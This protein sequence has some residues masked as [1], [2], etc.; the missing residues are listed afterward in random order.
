MEIWSAC[1]AKDPTSLNKEPYKPFDQFQRDETKMARCFCFSPCGKYF[2]WTNGRSVNICTTNNWK[3]IHE[4][5][6][7]RAFYLKFSPKGTYLMTWEQFVINKET[8]EG[9]PNL[10]IYKAE[11]GEDVFN[12]IQKRQTD[13]EPNWS[14]DEVLV[15]LMIGGEVLFYEPNS[16]DGFTK[17]VRKLGGKNGSVSMSPVNYPPHIAFYVPGVKAGM[18]NILHNFLIQIFINFLSSIHVPFIQVSK[19]G[20]QSTSRHKKVIIFIMII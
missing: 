4:L 16:A 19:F 3:I 13:W 7:P 20:D 12:I 9:A 8:Q 2:A 1:G 15:A 10:F 6:R 11:T 14:S 17:F 5:A 18:F